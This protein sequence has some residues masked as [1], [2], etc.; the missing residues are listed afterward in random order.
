MRRDE[1]VKLLDETLR[2]LQVGHYD[3]GGE[4][5]PLKLSRSEMMEVTVLLPDE[6]E[7]ICNSA[8]TA[9]KLEGRDTYRPLGG[10]CANEDSLDAARR[11]L[12][13]YD[14]MFEEGKPP[15]V[16]NFANPV[17]PGGGVRS[18]A[19]AQEEDLCRRSSLLLSLESDD[20]GRYYEYN[21][22]LDDLMSSDAMIFTPKVEV[23][24]DRDGALLEDTFVVAVLTCAAPMLRYGKGV[25]NEN[26]YRKLLYHRICAMLKCA[27]SFGYESVVLGAWGCGAFRN[28]ANVVSDLFCKALKSGLS[29]S[30][31]KLSLDDGG[32][33][34]ARDVFSRFDFAVLDRTAEQYNFNAFYRNFARKN[35]Y[36]REIAEAEAEMELENAKARK[37]IEESEVNL[38][39]IRGCLFGG[40]VGDALGYPVE[41]MNE[42]QIFM[43]FGEGGIR[44]YH[45]DSGLGKAKI[46]DDTQMSLFTATGL[47]Y[48]ETRMALRGISAPA[49]LYVADHYLDWLATQ[50]TTFEARKS[51]LDA[52]ESY[53]RC[54]HS[55]LAD[56]PRLY[57][58]RAP[59]R[60]CISALREI[61]GGGHSPR[62]P[63]KYPINSSKGCGGVMRVAPVALEWTDLH[64]DMQKLQSEAADVAAITH[65]HSLGYMSAGVLAHIVNRL[66]YPYAKLEEKSLKDIVLE[67]RDTAKET[68]ADDSHI[69]ELVSIINL[70]V[71]LADSWEDERECI[72]EIGEGWVAEEALAIAIFCSL[73]HQ[74]NF[75]EGIISAVNHKGD[76]DSTGSIAGNILGAR[77]GYNAIDEKW[78]Q[79]LELSDVILEIADDMCHG[80]IMDEYSSYFDKDWFDKYVEG[81]QANKQVIN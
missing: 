42:A 3:I 9:R 66:I 20:A 75:S 2:I 60:T 8:D 4:E 80:C 36:R 77:L 12:K 19:R 72:H 17:H 21:R 48:G 73:R 27:V 7:E 44:D 53:D 16:L 58:R 76:S 55:W 52:L 57:S 56:E 70:A 43:R 11:Q 63:R 45:I 47:L 79:N 29:A 50:E 41:F 37:K 49:H 54:G 15:L 40:A 62:Y 34:D 1:N 14:W 68:F 59:G 32:R 22:Y 10:D 24:R 33:K 31:I 5:I 39:K 61:K 13:D 25:L 26:E 74:D 71:R 38:D 23:I 35:F 81:H 28:D 78:K 69:G 30:G 46:S 18:G 65:G 67:A 6:V 51:E 64:R